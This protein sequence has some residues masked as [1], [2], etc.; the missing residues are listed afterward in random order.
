MTKIKAFFLRESVIRATYIL[1]S[2]II[3]VQHYI[4]GPQKYNNF[5]IFR[6]SFF[7]LLAE[8]NLHVPY[9]EEY[10]DIFLYHP[11]FAILFAPFSLMPMLP[12]LVLWLICCSMLLFYAIRH[13]PIS[14]A[15]KTF[16]WWYVLV[17]LVTSLHGQQTNP[18]IAALG[19]FTYIFLEKRQMK[20][21][22]L[23]PILAFCIKGY[24]VI[25]A[26]M[27]L[28]YPKRGQFILYSLLW[29]AALAILP[30]SVTGISH[31]TQAYKDWVICLIDDHKI[32]YGFSIM[33]LIKVW[34]HSFTE[35][36]VS[37]VQYA[38]VAIFALTWLW[39]VPAAVRSETHRF[40]L[41]SYAFLWVIL[42]NH[43]AESPTFIIAIQG[44]AIFY[45]VNKERMYP[46]STVLI[47]L[48]FWFSMLVPT[49]IY[50]LAWRQDFF[51]P[52]LIKVIP[53]LIFW[54]VLQRQL[55][56]TDANSNT[57]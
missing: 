25:F 13:L 11:S 38:G 49:D 8:K 37:Y 17:E 36:G 22:S 10:M 56:L 53:C 12:S 32:N 4:G 55:L 6:E 54:I 44:V 33:G 18:I 2:I 28:F 9:P 31:F 41:L 51:Q 19:L 20:W 23:F 45:I 3:G 35:Q 14:Y 21:A 15:Q 47:W 40:L 26:A 24:G 16:F 42:F 39:N 43:A 46:W 50:P 48:A 1:L 52:Y 5:I 34:W 30:L 27:F 29:A 57:L 7:H